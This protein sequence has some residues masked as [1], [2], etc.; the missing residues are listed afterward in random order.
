MGAGV[1]R[2]AGK[3]TLVKSLAV[4]IEHYYIITNACSD[5]PNVELMEVARIDVR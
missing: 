2:A 4:S 1:V 3:V 5:Y